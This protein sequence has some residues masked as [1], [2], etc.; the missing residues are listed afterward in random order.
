MT[1]IKFANAGRTLGRGGG[2][3]GGEKKW[4][5][6]W[7]GG[8]GN[9]SKSTGRGGSSDWDRAWSER[10]E[11]DPGEDPRL[12]RGDS[13]YFASEESTTKG[14]QGNNEKNVQTQKS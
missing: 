6:D 9:T 12:Q 8:W 1:I 10:T 7:R 11:S 2:G 3:A 13:D 14:D 4:G 5:G